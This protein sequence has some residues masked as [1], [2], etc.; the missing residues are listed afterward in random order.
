MDT[1]LTTDQLKAATG[2]SRLSDLEKTLRQNGIRFLYGK[3]GKPFTT[4]TAINAAM[5]INHQ[6]GVKSDTDNIDIY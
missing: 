2:C 5:G 1:L 3:N 4:L 6:T